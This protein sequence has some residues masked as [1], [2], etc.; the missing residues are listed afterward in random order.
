MKSKL[1]Q[2]IEQHAVSAGKALADYVAQHLADG[3]IGIDFEHNPIA[4]FLFRRTATD[5]LY[6]FR[7]VIDVDSARLR[8]WATE[9]VKAGF[10]SG[11][12]N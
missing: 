8:S 2:E 1:P 6:R 7:C 3:L 12:P 9:M 5:V 10:E 11:L 4:N